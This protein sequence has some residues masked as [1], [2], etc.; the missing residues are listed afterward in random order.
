M[1]TALPPVKGAAFSF[2]IA[3]VSQADT[4]I[5]KT[6]VTITTADV[7]VSKDGGAFAAVTA[8]PTEL[9]TGA[10]AE[11][12]V[13]WQG[14]TATEM[15]A[16]IVTV[17]YHDAADNEWQDAVVTIYTAGQTLGTLAATQPAVTWG[18]QKIA[19]DVAGEGALDIRNNNALGY[20]VYRGGYRGVYNRGTHTGQVNQGDNTGLQNDGMLMDMSG[21]LQGSVLGSVASVVDGVTLANDAI[22]AGKFDEATAFPLKSADAG[23]TAVART[24]AD[25]DTLESLSD[26]VDLTALEAT[27]TAIKGAGWTTESLRALD[28]LLDAIKAKTDMIGEGA[29]TVAAPVSMDGDVE[30]DQGYDYYAADG[31]ALEWTNTDST[32][33]D[34]TGA[35]AWFMVGTYLSV[36]GSISNPTGPATIRVQLSRA[37]TALL[38]R[39]L[40]RFVIKC[41]L[42]N[43]HVV[44]QV[45]GTVT[46]R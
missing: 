35:T 24:G 19:A 25:G 28:A 42:T 15:N 31:R 46:V 26:Q 30:L 23:A 43:G 12:G 6:T 16:D 41:V 10:A 33:P 18:Q 38:P 14:L 8:A 3:L 17:L 5:F 7:W 4:D 9:L 32:W 44:L 29:V 27:L 37:Q 11:M 22:T 1:A 40:R 2:A 20:G 39:G 13:L 36:T 34:L 21:D 45:R